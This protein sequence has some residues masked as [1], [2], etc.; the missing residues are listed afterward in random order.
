MAAVFDSNDHVVKVLLDDDEDPVAG[1][2]ALAKGSHDGVITTTFKPAL[3]KAGDGDSEAQLQKLEEEGDGR[4]DGHEERGSWSNKREYILTM[5]GYIVGIGNIWRFPYMCNRNGGGAFLFPFILCLAFM[6][7]PLFFLE[8]ALG[9][10]TGRSPLHVWSVCPLVKGMGIA[11]SILSVMFVWYFNTIMSWALYYMVSSFQSVLPWSLCGQWWNTPRCSDLSSRTANA[12]GAANITSGWNVTTSGWNASSGWNDNATYMTTMSMLGSTTGNSTDPKKIK[13][14][15]AAEEFWQ[16]NVLQMSDGFFETGHLVWYLAVM[17]VI[18][19]LFIFLALLKGVKSSGKVVYVTA[20]APYVLLTVLVVRGVTLPGAADGILFYITP[21]FQKLLDPLVWLE[22][23]L[24]VFY[25]LGPAWG[26]LIAVASYNKFE[27]NCFRDAVIL[28]FIGE[29]TS[30][31]GGFA[32]FSVLG[33]MAHQTGV[34]IDKVVSSGPGLAFV[35]YPE[36]ISLLPLPQLWAVFFFIMVITI[37]IDTQLTGVETFLTVIC[38]SFPRTLGR[39]RLLVTGI[40][41]FIALVSSLVL[42]SQGGIY[43]FQL[44]DWFIATLTVTT[45]ALL[46]CVVMA[47]VYGADRFS[48]DIQLMVGR[49]PPM[50]IKILWCF[51]IPVLLA[52]LLVVTLIK[53][54]PPTLGDYKYD[55]VSTAIGWC[56][57]LSSFIP[58]PGMAVYQLLKAKGTFMQRLRHTITP[59]EH[60]GPA[61]PTRRQLYRKQMQQRKPRQRLLD[62]LR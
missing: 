44:F 25:S 22:A 43:I 17:Q 2:K 11:M 27:N 56:I 24:Q 6:G 53:Y 49:R 36:A 45:V 39:R 51:V 54:Q 9:Q 16:H 52:V 10:F 7:F 3:S 33:Y 20:T 30:V 37:V 62:V 58:I 12:T 29:G 5:M 23:A 18:V 32:I 47:W 28:S 41:C 1:E 26:G 48:E 60:W 4:G 40:Y 42:V 8:S 14:V 34:P 50:I 59:D 19:I 35:V 21:D 55:S 61:D 13:V 57:A 46:E 31:F 15:T 38:D